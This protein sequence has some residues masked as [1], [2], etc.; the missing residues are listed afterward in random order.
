MRS[1]LICFILDF[2]REHLKTGSGMVCKST[3]N[4]ET[5]IEVV[6]IISELSELMNPSCFRVY[7]SKTEVSQRAHTHTNV[8]YGE[9]L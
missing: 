2:V 8:N 9:I 3:K 7:G 4:A 5:T 1:F 6:V